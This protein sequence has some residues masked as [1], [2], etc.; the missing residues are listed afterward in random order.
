MRMNIA[1][2]LLVGLVAF[3]VGASAQSAKATA[4]VNEL[5]NLTV[6]S[7]PVDLTSPQAVADLDWSTILEQTI[8]V[9]NKKDLFVT[10]S[11][12]CGLL[13]RTRVQTSG[14]ATDTQWADAGVRVRVVYSNDGGTTWYT[15]SPDS[16]RVLD[17]SGAFGGGT[18]VGSGVSFCRR[19][20]QLE[21]KLQGILDCPAGAAIPAGCTL[22]DEE[23]ELLL[24]TL[25]ANAFTFLVAD[26][27]SGTYLV[28]VEAVGI[29]NDS[30]NAAS[31]AAV[32][33]AGSVTIEEVRMIR[34]EDITF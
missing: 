31:S 20:Q 1:L 21:A 27:S 15:A 18:A 17:G 7:G 10:V 9:A 13:T 19:F 26:L 4:Q 23:I 2:G 29:V 8:K 34:G 33:G 25:D 28:K 3:P 32:A 11:L 24:S 14:G 16:G 30:G 12:E 6:S 22:T 5:V